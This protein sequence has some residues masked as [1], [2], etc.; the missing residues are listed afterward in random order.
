MSTLSGFK[1][2]FLY[3]AWCHLVSIDSYHGV[4]VNHLKA[5]GNPTSVEEPM[6]WPNWR[7]A[8]SA[9]SGAIARPWRRCVHQVPG[10]ETCVGR[11]IASSSCERWVSERRQQACRRCSHSRDHKGLAC[12]APVA[13]Q[14]LQVYLGHAQNARG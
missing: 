5:I 14:L 9:A 3:T 4:V 11:S 12:R 1:C 7:G 13:R 2:M 8:Y 6:G 10:L